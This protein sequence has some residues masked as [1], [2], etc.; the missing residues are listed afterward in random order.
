MMLQVKQ[1][2]FT[3][4]VP[5]GVTSPWL[6]DLQNWKIFLSKEA[7]THQDSEARIPGSSPT[8]I[9]TRGPVADSSPSSCQIDKSSPDTA[10]EYTKLKL[11]NHAFEL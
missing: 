6:D 5:L 10:A 7:G 9:L 2:Q 3:L 1:P 4:L 11:E 8:V